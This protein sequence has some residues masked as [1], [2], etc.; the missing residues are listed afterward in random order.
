LKVEHAADAAE[1]RYGGSRPL[2]LNTASAAGV[3]RNFKQGA[4][5]LRFLGVDADPAAEHEP[6]VD[7]LGR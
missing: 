4:P 5:G 6:A 7:L 1:G 3:A 2:A